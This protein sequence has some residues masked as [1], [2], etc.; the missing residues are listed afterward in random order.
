M[1]KGIDEYLLTGRGLRI[2]VVGAG[3]AGLAV[4]KILRDTEQF[5]SGH[6]KIDC[7]ED[8]EDVGGTW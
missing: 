1:L 2:C 4:L 3:A 6:W 7:F 5:K 8:R